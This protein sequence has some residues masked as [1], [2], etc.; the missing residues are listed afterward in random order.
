MP[1]K[2]PTLRI[3]RHL[4]LV[5]G[6]TLMVVMGVS[7]I[8]PILPD[9][10]RT[11][12]M[13]MSSVGM[14]F[15]AF[16]LPG[17]VLTPLGG[18]LAD[19][20]GRKKV[21]I[22]SLLL[23]AA[24]GVAC[25]FAPSLPVLLACRFVQGIG[26]APLGVLYTTIIGDLYDGNQRMQAMGFNA[27]V[28][29]LGTAIYPA[30]G[31]LLGEL[32]W[33]VPFLL[34]LLALPLCFAIARTTFPEP[35]SSQGMGEYFR[36]TWGIISSPRAITLFLLTLFTF[37]I[38][39]G[40]MV[41]FFPVL[42]DQQ[43]HATPSQ[44]GFVFSIASAGTVLTAVRLGTLARLIR[45]VRLLLASHG[46]YA[47]AMVTMPF[48]P[49][50]WWALAPVFIFGLAQGLNIPNTATLLTDL[51]PM[52]GRA[53]IMAVNGTVLRLAQTIGPVLAGIAFAT[54]GLSGVY[55]FGAFMAASMAALIL[56][57]GLR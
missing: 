1:E 35:R 41:T 38:L 37:L 10:A 17:V 56:A 33:R 50:L 54:G 48:V 31:G 15:M 46:L 16:T 40:P 25:A 49:S 20:I 2:A 21:L 57:R 6:I 45:P 32:G 3:G 29:S 39:Y 8:M 43:F 11:F 14:V 42:A 18:I 26:A 5:F 34:P 55:T 4:L 52:E 23:F 12:D 22:P 7:S 19:R 47:L 53:A 9:L 30:V 28:L 13:P 44:I 36:S 51:A 24:G 27:G